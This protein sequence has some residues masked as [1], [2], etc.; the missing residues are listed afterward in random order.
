M[1][2]LETQVKAGPL[3]LIGNTPV[4]NILNYEY[5]KADVR[6]KLESFNPGGSIKDRV[7]L[8]IINDAESRR[9]IKPGNELVEATSGNTGIGIAWIGRLKGYKVTIVTHD[10]ASA[11]KLALLKFYGASVVIM[12]S[13]AAP[14]S[15]DHYVNVAIKHASVPGRFFCDQFNNVAN[16]H[17]HYKSTGP[18]LWLQGGRDADV[19]ICGV[20][21]GGTLSGIKKYFREKGSAAKFVVADPIGSIYHSYFSKGSYIARSWQVEGIGSN[22]IPGI[23]RGEVVDDVIPVRD[24]DS[25]SACEFIRSRYSVDIGLSTGTA[26]AAAIQM[27]KENNSLRIMIISP[28]SG[29]RYI[30]KLNNFRE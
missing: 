6:L 2:T 28:D 20:G 27:L 5:P 15:S 4:V 12:P 24:V 14:D 11:E 3:K 7:A 29:E 18:E 22:F 25:F 26:V 23:I 1:D 16:S 8:E 9:V 19:I 13:D 17:S 10:K 21:S 30:S